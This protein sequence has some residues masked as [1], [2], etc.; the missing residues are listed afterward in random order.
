MNVFLLNYLKHILEIID[1]KIF[2]TAINIKE[3]VQN[4]SQFTSQGS[5]KS[6]ISLLEPGT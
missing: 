3:T 5:L 2:K 1:F 6:D 4:C